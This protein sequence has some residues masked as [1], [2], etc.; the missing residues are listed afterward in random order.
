MDKP[1][2]KETYEKIAE[3]IME[4][5]LEE[6][7]NG[8]RIMYFDEISEEF[9]VTEEWIKNHTADIKD[10]FN[11]EVVAECLIDDEC[12][13][14]MFYLQYCCERCGVYKNGD[15]CHDECCS[16]EC[17]CDSFEDEE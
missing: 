1:N 5:G 8:S 7:T 9:N 4:T 14:M 10:C 12:F 15:R 13:D 2:L 17:W 6:T 3:R 11:Y 16:C